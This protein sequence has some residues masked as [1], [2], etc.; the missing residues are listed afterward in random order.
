MTDLNVTAV[1]SETWLSANNNIAVSD[2][3][4]EVWFDTAL[5]LVTSTVGSEIWVDYNTSINI[6]VTG[7]EVWFD[8]SLDLIVS[9]IGSEVW[10]NNT[11]YIPIPTKNKPRIIAFGF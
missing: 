5:S 10:I 1:G 8:T 6:D 7:S 2:T 3:L 9:I 4:A 11:E